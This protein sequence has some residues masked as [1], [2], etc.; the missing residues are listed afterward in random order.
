MKIAPLPAY[1]Q[2]RLASLFSYGV[3][4]TVAEKSYDELTELA[5]TICDVPISLI[6]LVDSKRQW[7]KSCIGLDAKE[8]SRDIA[9]C[10]HAILQNEV[11]I[12]EDTLKDER[13]CDNPLVTSAP[14]IRFYAGA[15]LFSPSGHAI[16]TLCV[17]DHKPRTLN[18]AQINA[19]K[20]L[21]NQVVIQ[22]ELRLTVKKLQEHAKALDEV[23]ATKNKFFSIISHDLR[24]PFIGILGFSEMLIEELRTQPIEE[25]IEMAQ[26][27][28][29]TAKNASELLDNLLQ[30]SLCETGGINFKPI[31]LKVSAIVDKTI[32]LLKGVAD[33][34]KIN[35]RFASNEPVEVIADENMLSSIFRNLISNA[36]KF[37]PSEGSITVSTY[38]KDGVAHCT[39]EDNGVGMTN[40]KVEKLFKP[41][42]SI[43]TSGT[44]GEVGNGLGLLLTKQFIEKN[45]GTVRVSSI[46]GKGT[47][48][49][50]TIPSKKQ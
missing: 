49:S 39:V 7:F 26:D 22:L 16:G 29:S 11:F 14:N 1:E 17:I 38:E 44:E 10:S 8:T 41:G 36:L 27:I 25:S 43:S 48:F 3:L 18:D 35:I 24:T 9:F 20:T 13:F 31:A 4:D 19:L 12:V 21:A 28:H 6:S 42:I 37:T 46:V 47:K 50:F 30:W 33:Q 45:C 15:P 2:S 34:K 23:N 5:A 40:E 32:N